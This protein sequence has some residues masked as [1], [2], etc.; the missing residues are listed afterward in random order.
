MSK[1]QSVRET[2]SFVGRVHATPA[3]LAALGL[4]YGAAPVLGQSQAELERFFEGKMAVVKIDMPAS[5]DGVDVHPERAQPI[6]YSKYGK[7][8]K[9]HGTA[10]RPGD[11]VMITKLKLK[12]R[13]I[14]LQLGGGGYGTF[15]DE[16]G[17]VA[18]NYEPP[19]ERERELK[20][21]IKA[22]KDPAK[23]AEL[24]REYDDLKRERER[25]NEMQEVLAGAASEHAKTRV[26]TMALGAGSRFNIRYES[27]LTV[28]VTTPE[29]VMAALAEYLEFPAE[30]FG[31]ESATVATSE[32]PAS[33]PIVELRRGLLWDE[34]VALLGEP[35]TVA[36][37]MEGSLKVSICSFSR[38]DR[39]VE[40]EFIEGVLIRYSVTAADLGTQGG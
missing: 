11:R 39:H 12:E 35:T 34:M 4:L 10:L 26:R 28:E 17:Y 2:G 16:S 37:R 6:N 3:F 15:G 23:R 18:A 21:A 32:S 38:G 9:Q 25:A 24:Q 30:S 20:K 33:D 1:R 29:S 14:E 22:E 13:H 31:V 19:S 5:K 27:P 7:R 40:A 8:L 36:E